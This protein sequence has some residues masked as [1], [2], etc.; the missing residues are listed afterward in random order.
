M[1]VCESLMMMGPKEQKRTQKNEELAK[2]S[3]KSLKNENGSL[4]LKHIKQFNN[5]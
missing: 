3:Y 4:D 1:I 5:G 2:I